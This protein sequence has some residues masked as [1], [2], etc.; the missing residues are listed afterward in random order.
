MRLKRVSFKKIKRIRWTLRS[1]SVLLILCFSTATQTASKRKRFQQEIPKD[2]QI[3]VALCKNFTTSIAAASDHF[4]HGLTSLF[5]LFDHV[6]VL[7]F[8]GC[9]TQI[10]SSLLHKSSCIEGRVLDKCSPDRFLRGKEKHGLKVTFMHASVIELAK[11]AAY[12]NILILEDDTILLNRRLAPGVVREMKSLVRGSGW[13]VIRF[14]LRP[15]FLQERGTEHCPARCRCDIV[16]KHSMHLCRLRRSGC[17]I[18]SSNFYA[19]HANEFSSFQAKLLD[20]RASNLDRIIDT[21]PLR[22]LD[23]H[24]LFLPQ[25][26]I[27]GRL[28]IPFDYQ[29]GLVAL[30]VKKC[31]LPRPLPQEVS[32]QI[33]QSGYTSSRVDGAPYLDSS[34]RASHLVY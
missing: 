4:P 31:V 19:V 8:D 12:N 14:S 20:T 13:S 15:Y 3:S 21:V 2:F 24:W 30:Y 32:Q 29:I 5:S 25:L 17:D 18:R 34:E 28:D 23:N 1:L 16:Q 33:F 9:R 10:P 22:Q 27:Q 26:A 11:R 6:F 7:S